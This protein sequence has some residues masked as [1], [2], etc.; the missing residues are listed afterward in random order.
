MLIGIDASRAATAQRTGTEGYAFHLIRALLPIATQRGHTVRLYFNTPPAIDTFAAQANVEQVIL[1]L[2]RLWT[3]LR[4]GRELRQRPPD[5]FFT[6]AHVIPIGYRGR[7]VA[8]V[9]DLGYHHFPQ[10]HTR[11]QVAYLRWSTRHNARRSKIVLADSR[12]TKA[13]L[14]QFYG[15]ASEK[16]AVVYPG[17][18]QSVQKVVDSAEITTTTTK[19]NI[20]APYFIHIGTLQPRKNLERLIAAFAQVADTLP[21]QLVLAGRAGWL[22]ESI[23]AAIK[24]LPEPIR[25]RIVVTGFLP[26]EDKAAL[27]SGATALLFPSLHEGF[28]FPVLEAQQCDLPVLCANTSSLPEIAGDAALYV[29]PLAVDDIAHGIKRLTDDMTLRKQLIKRGRDNA[30]RFDWAVSA[31]TTLA[32]F[33]QV[34]D[35][36]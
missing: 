18:D 2:P 8:T 5:V 4:L 17:S 32:I 26:D 30:R 23:L 25:Q 28:G 20:T 24:Q 36:D 7:S 34:H 6:P 3:H 22:A 13:D 11:R 35:R 27:L 12:A 10:A 14:M 19:H 31:E 15:V 33:E 1:P 9:H 16:I 29:D 21:H